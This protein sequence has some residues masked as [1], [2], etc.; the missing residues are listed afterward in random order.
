VIGFEQVG[1]LLPPE[2]LI[3]IAYR[4][5]ALKDGELSGL[6][7]VLDVQY[8]NVW[9]NIPKSLFDQIH[10]V[11]GDPIR[12]RIYHGQQLID[13]SV[14]P[15]RRTFGEVPLGQPLLYINSLLNVAVALNQGNFA[16][17]HKV[18]SGL[19]WFIVISK[20]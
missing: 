12:V 8:G 3:R 15:Y 10:P 20:K 7:P 16:A 18:E 17:V 1:P 19:D 9:T 14:A 4:K 6:I 2:K 11:I 13:E 5:P